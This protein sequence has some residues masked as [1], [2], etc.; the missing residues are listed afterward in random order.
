VTDS[1]PALA[2]ALPAERPWP[3]ALVG[4]AHIIDM[5]FR[6]LDMTRLI[7]SLTAR[8]T[9]DPDDAAALM[10]LASIFLVLHKPEE[11]LALQR[12]ALGIEQVYRQPIRTATGRALRILM[13]AGPG[14]FMANMPVEFLLEGADISLDVIYLLPG[15]PLPSQVPDHDIAIVGIAESDE[16]GPILDHLSSIVGAWPTR[17]LVDPQA[18]KTLSRERLW[19]V[20][21]DAPGVRIPPTIRVDRDTVARLAQTDD[22][23]G[24]VLAG[25]RYPIIVR[26]VGSHAGHGLE[27][28]DGAMH[29]SAY[30]ERVSSD[31][32]YLSPFVD[33]RSADGLFR[34]YRIA[35][36]DGRPFAC[37]MAMADHWMLHYLNAGMEQSAE[38]RAQE[39]QWFETFDT[40]FADRHRDAFRVLHERIGLE[41]LV[42]DCAE[43]ATG[44][45][46]VFEA[47]TAMVVHAMDS[48]DLF[49]YKHAPMRR[50]FHA[51]QSMLR[52]HA[53]ADPRAESTGMTSPIKGAGHS[54]DY[55]GVAAAF[56]RP[57]LAR[58]PA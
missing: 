1:L 57:G 13:F 8:A 15:Q 20:L 14:D 35:L 28:I 34:K 45:L 58:T 50:L 42:L 51:F 54:S 5:A 6:G 7:N 52:T 3:P 24:G 32:F 46:L 2:S 27:K 21:S 16:N 40:A 55:L 36:V 18:I 47:D 23:L 12:E 48:S 39:A 38:K 43:T 30:L 31:R 11:G 41:Y 29:L 37:H 25:A 4:Q 9:T 44:E 22:A 53:G 10:D 19:Q 33:Y 17:V 26:P 49:P 56:S